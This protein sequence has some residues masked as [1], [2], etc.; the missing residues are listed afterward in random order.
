MEVWKNLNYQEVPFIVSNLGNVRVG[1]RRNTYKRTRNGVEHIVSKQMAEQTYTPQA[2]HT[3]YHSIEL[4]HNGKR[5]RVLL[6]KLVAL[7][8]V[9]GFEEG[10]CVNHINGIKTDNRAD[11]LEWV[12]LARNTQ[13]AWETGLVDLR[14]EAQP[15]HKL[16]SKQVVYIRRLLQQGISAHSLAIIAGVDDVTIH[17]I[18]V[19]KRWA[20]IEP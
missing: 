11:N 13:H 9:D 19:G 6:H 8:H 16:T 7:A 3:G 12:S 4:R 20:H 18:K 5:V 2:H 14:G 1:A 17:Y 15:T 10:L